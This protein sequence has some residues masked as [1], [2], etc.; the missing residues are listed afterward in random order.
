[1]TSLQHELTYAT[2]VTPALI[3]GAHLLAL[4]DLELE[5]HVREALAANPALEDD[6]DGCPACAA[7]PGACA[8]PAPPAVAR[9]GTLLSDGDLAEESASE[10]AELVT[11]AAALLP[12]ADRPLLDYIAADVDAR[13]FLDRPPG[14]LAADLC[15]PEASVRRVIDALRHVAPAGFCAVDLVECLLLQLDA[16]V[17]PP[18][19]LRQM[20]ERHLPALAR[21]RIASVA[22]ELGVPTS[23]VRAATEYLRARL[24][25]SVPVDRGLPRPPRLRPDLV[26]AA[27]DGELRVTLATQPRLRLHHDFISLASDR[28]RLARL[29]PAEREVLTRTLADATAF[30]DRLALRGRTLHRVGTEIAARQRTF[31]LGRA[32]AP[33]PMTRA[34]VAATLGLHESTVSRAV[35]DKLAQLPTGRVVPLGNLFGKSR[36]V[37][38]CMRALVA[39]E[40]GALSDADLVRALAT[41]GHVVGRST[42]RKYRQQLG[43]PAQHLR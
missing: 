40:D 32:S 31:L 21:G 3:Q 12:A 7:A 19:I 20:I 42:V 18:A 29:T 14:H 8:C 16:A 33:V 24:R 26:F 17:D 1:M 28:D 23:E 27:A 25:P 38:E 22:R 6:R 11:A 34:D 35:K 9:P 39:A 15:I 37:Q 43:I 30:L 10:L 4:A 36:T 5:Q 41:Q 2:T 13:G